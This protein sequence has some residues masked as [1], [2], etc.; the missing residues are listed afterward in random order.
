[1]EASKEFLDTLDMDYLYRKKN[2]YHMLAKY[3]LGA[4]P[5]SLSGMHQLMRP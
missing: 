5:R 3:R 4:Y 2:T 1:M